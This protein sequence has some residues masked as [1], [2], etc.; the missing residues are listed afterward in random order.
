M[1]DAARALHDL[2][3]ASVLV[4]GGHLGGDR[5]VDVFFDGGAV[6]ELASPRVDTGDTHGTGCTLA[7][8][9]AAHL[10]RGRDL[11]AAV[12]LAKDFVGEAIRHGL[13]LGRGHG[14]VNPGWA[15]AGRR[16]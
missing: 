15:L 4:K 14:P 6:V 16:P 8:A 5:A 9:I 13:R 1:R 2:G 7:S 10:A 3:P 12:R 11:T